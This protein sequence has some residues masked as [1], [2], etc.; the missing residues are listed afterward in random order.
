MNDTNDLFDVVNDQ[1]L[2]DDD[3]MYAAMGYEPDMVEPRDVWTLIDALNAVLDHAEHSRL[4][5]DF[6][7]ICRFPLEYLTLALDMTN[8]Q[9]AVLAFMIEAG[10]SVSW[11]KMG[12]YFG[13]RRIEMMTYTEE[14]E[15]LVKRRW[16]IRRGSREPRGMSE[17]FALAHGVVTA[18][19]KNQIFIPE[20]LSHLTTQQLI[21][22]IDNRLQ[23]SKHSPDIRFCDDEEY[24]LELL[25]ENPEL[26]ICQEALRFRDPH[27]RSL[28]LLLAQ[29]YVRWADMSGEGMSISEIS[30]MYDSCNVDSELMGMELESGSHALMEHGWVE[31]KCEEGM[32]DAT[33]VVLTTKAKQELLAD[34][35]PYVRNNKRKK[36]D[37]SLKSYTLVKEKSLFYNP[38][39][40][41]QVERLTELLQRDNFANV[42]QRMED[43]GMRKGF[44]CL[45]YGA[46]GTGKTETVLQLARQTGR[47]IMQ[48]DIAGMRDKWVGESEKNIKAV[49]ARYRELCKTAEIMPILFFNEADGIFGKRLESVGHSVDKMENSMQN[50][51]LEEMENLDGILIAT[52]NLTSNLDRAFERRFLFKVEFKKP[53]TDVLS[54]I[55]QTLLNGISET[56]AQCLASRY[57]FSGGQIENIARKRMVDYILN[58][59]MPSREQL[60]TYCEEELLADKSA[61]KHIAGFFA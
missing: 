41:Q 33:C 45:F 44:A 53:E 31:H 60:E 27:A 47:N 25:T 14:I 3:L 8:V 20:D 42:Q 55:W 23:S 58:G 52:T 11:R 40:R 37:R 39:E 9:V 36:D 29:D 43:A 4:S 13:I 22:R 19:R 26:P 5:K 51:I 2:S 50:I 7:R 38:T 21:G 1:F 6:F 28:L 24:I 16:V 15:D 17:G 32:V 61:P 56:D 48:I 59:A 57:P 30:G 12:R 46:P 10:E 34:V 54:Q 18:M 35:K 49:F